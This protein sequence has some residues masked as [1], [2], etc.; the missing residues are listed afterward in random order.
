VRF[1]IRQ[2]D[3]LIRQVIG[4][5]EFCDG[6]ECIF[7]LQWGYAWHDLRLS[8]GT[9]VGRGDPVLLLHLWNEHVPP[10]G[11]AGPDLAWAVA[12]RRML[13]FSLRRLARWLIETPQRSPVRAIGGVTI[14]ASPE[15]GGAR[16]LERLGFEVFPHRSPLGRF[17]EYWENFYV[18]WLM[19]T[20]NAASL[21][22]RRLLNLHRAEIW[23][24]TQTLL[25]RYG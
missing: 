18:W 11:A 4:V 6:P 24:S 25:E 17:G 3:R 20:Y 10:M 12:V 2:L 5:F 9:V 21:R 16:L 22:Q 23:L 7:R 13:L 19:W 14:L 15:E 1:L 8:D